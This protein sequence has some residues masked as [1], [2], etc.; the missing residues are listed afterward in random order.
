MRPIEDKDIDKWFDEAPV[1]I[2]LEMVE[3]ESKE[4]RIQREKKENLKKKL[5]E[6]IEKK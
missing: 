3:W 5:E 1:E 2:D 6:I 4:Q